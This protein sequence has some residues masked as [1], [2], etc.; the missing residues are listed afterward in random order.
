MFKKILVPLD[1][2]ALASAALLP[3]STLARRDNAELLLVGVTSTSTVAEIGAYL[4]TMVSCLSEE[5]LTVRAMLPPGSPENEISEEAELA[6]ADLIVMTTHG[7][8][9]L[10]ALLHPSVT[11]RVLAQTNA[12]LLV[13]RYADEEQAA[14]SV[15]Q[16]RFLT[17]ATAPILVP[18]DGSPQAE[19]VLLPAQ[20]MAEEFGNPLVLLRVGEPLL[21]AES[22]GAQDLMP[23]GSVGYWMEEAEAY[24]RQKRK[25]LARAGLRVKTIAAPGTPAEVIQAAAREYQA[26]LIVIA[27]RGR[28]WLGRLVMGSVARNVLSQSQTPILLVRRFEPVPAEG[29]KTEQVLVEAG[30]W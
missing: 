27:S 19:Q 21:L 26:G 6:R 11:W 24:L 25:E 22:L 3:A 29:V 13:S 4:A 1:G 5:G 10:D 14:P 2:S 16:L 9:G 23:G 8:T 20:E 17:D 15:H 12:P 18:L 28:G 7:R 30:A